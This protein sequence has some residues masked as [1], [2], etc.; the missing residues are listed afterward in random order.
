[1][2]LI[3]GVIVRAAHA[4]CDGK[5]APAGMLK[6]LRLRNVLADGAYSKR[7]ETDLK[8]GV[9]VLLCKLIYNYFAAQDQRC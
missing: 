6:R 1:L 8:W 7:S 9:N 4:A 3:I 5:A 2:G